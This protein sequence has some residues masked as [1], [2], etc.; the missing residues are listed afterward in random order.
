MRTTHTDPTL[1]YITQTFVEEDDLL[2]DVRAQGEALRAGMQIS[3]LEGKLLYVLASLIQARRI[4]EVG[5]FVGYS[6]LWLAR[7]L[8][9]DGRLVT[10][11]YDEKHA[12]YAEAFFTRSAFAHTIG[13]RRGA[14]LETLAAMRDETF[15]LV[16]I[17]AMKREYSDYLDCVEP[18]LRPGGLVVGDNT[19]L[20]GAMI[21]KPQQG[22]SADAIESI[23]RFN[24]RL[25]DPTRY[26]SI[27]LPTEEGLTVAQ[28]IV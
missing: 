17:D 2:R 7:A 25:A 26:R 3:P 18:M 12:N 16:F 14:A 27:L 6:T 20:F 15:D 4:L 22:V 10:L 11:E 8:P 19:L 9:T 28:K 24:T 23:R 21:G 13:L 1:H 5:T